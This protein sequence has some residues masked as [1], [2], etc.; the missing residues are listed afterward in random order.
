MIQIAIWG[1]AA[2]LV[3]KALDILHQQSISNASNN[4]GSFSLS[5]GAAVLAILSAI[6]LV[7]LTNEQVKSGEGL[8]PLAQTSVFQSNADAVDSSLTPENRRLRDSILAEGNA[9]EAMEGLS[10]TADALEAAADDSTR[11]LRAK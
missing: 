9:A 11:S 3:V 4:A 6:G 1:I 5:T 8:S 2:M 10:A 7:W